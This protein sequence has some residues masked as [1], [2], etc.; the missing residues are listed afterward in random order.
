MDMGDKKV[1]LD[2]QVMTDYESL[3]YKQVTSLLWRMYKLLRK[4]FILWLII[5]NYIYYLKVSN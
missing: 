2:S 4:V 1:G 3:S 5:I